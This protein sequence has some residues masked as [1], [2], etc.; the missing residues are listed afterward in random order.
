MSYLKSTS[1]QNALRRAAGIATSN[2]KISELIGSV[3]D[4][5]SDMDENKKRASDFIKK[6]GTLLRML[7]A[8]INGNYRQIPFKS[9]LMII[10]ALIYF[11]MPL[12]LIPDFIPVTGLADDISIIFLVF[13]S[14]NEDI[15][16]FLE[17]E[18]SVLNKSSDNPIY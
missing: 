15:N 12:D 1:F 13:T 6:V 8:Y 14:I 11:L 7:R 2:E 16:A 5:M 17:F 4:K 18:K 10:G 9:L 3:T